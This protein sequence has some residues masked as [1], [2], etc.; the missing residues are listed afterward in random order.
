MS[1]RVDRRRQTID[2]HQL[3]KNIKALDLILDDADQVSIRKSHVATVIHFPMDDID[4]PI[5]SNELHEFTQVIEK[6]R[7]G[8]SKKTFFDPSDVVTLAMGGGEIWAHQI[9][10]SRDLKKENVIDLGVVQQVM[11]VFKGTTILELRDD[12]NSRMTIG[13]DTL[14]SIESHMRFVNSIIKNGKFVS[15]DKIKVLCESNK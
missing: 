8:F 9:H 10:P 1:E 11:T 15:S 14:S 3:Y 12:L 5:D 13:K 6:E 7:Y 2:S 4:F